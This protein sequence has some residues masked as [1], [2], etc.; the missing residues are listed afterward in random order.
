M[1]GNV[2]VE[3]SELQSAARTPRRQKV[4]R[5]VVADGMARFFLAKANAAGA[6]PALDREFQTEGEAMVESLRTGLSYY[7]VVEWRAMADFAG[8]HPQVKKE[9]VKKKG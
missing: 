7:S 1:A 8:K 2:V 3:A 9:V 5:E 6:T 4:A